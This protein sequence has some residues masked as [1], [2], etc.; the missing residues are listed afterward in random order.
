MLCSA[1]GARLSTVDS[2]CLKQQS[3]RVPAIPPGLPLLLA[4]MPNGNCNNTLTAG[5]TYLLQQA[6]V[7]ETQIYGPVLLLRSG[8]HKPSLE[9][10]DDTNNTDVV[11]SQ[12]YVGDHM[13]QG[14]QTVTPLS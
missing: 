12:M 2:K 3:G 11:F 5:L 10:N 6:R 4:L 14:S 1:S 9:A 7:D 8:V 13:P